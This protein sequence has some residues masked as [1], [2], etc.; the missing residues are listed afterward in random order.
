[1]G[2]VDGGV[3]LQGTSEGQQRIKKK[4][5]SLATSKEL[6]GPAHSWAALKD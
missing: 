6:S 4:K 5:V 3:L 1:M 2:L